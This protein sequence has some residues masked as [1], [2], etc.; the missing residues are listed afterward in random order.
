VTDAGSANSAVQGSEV[1]G[2]YRIAEVCPNGHVSTDSADAHPE[3]REKFCSK[4]GEVTITHCSNC[5]MGIRGD[6]FVEGYYSADSHYVPPAYCFN[7]GNAF[8]WTNRRIA[9]AVELLEA[10]GKLSPSE[11]GQ[12][13]SDLIVMTKETPQT[14]VASLRFKKVMLKVGSSVADGVRTIIVDV[15]SEAAKKAILG[16]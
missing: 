1:M 12:F 8:E 2:T 4:C 6:Y 9:G 10:D 5:K 15:L 11:I 13:R 14:Q 7:C 3:L 16:Q